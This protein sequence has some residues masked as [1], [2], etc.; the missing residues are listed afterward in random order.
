MEI[1]PGRGVGPFLFGLTE[2][3]LIRALGPPDKRYTTDSEA[4]RLQYF[5]AQLEFSLEPDNGHRFGWI[6][7]HNPEATL[8]GRRVLGEPIA[9]VLSRVSEAFAEEP[10]HEDYGGLE[11][12][13]YARHWL[14]LQVEFGRVVSVHCGVIYDAADEPLWPAVEPGLIAE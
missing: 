11:T 6:E 14:E 12:Y 1:R 5:G 10:E 8:F 9:A 7:V 3:E 4:L 2:P 13:F